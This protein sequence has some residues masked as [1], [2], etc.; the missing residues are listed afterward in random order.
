MRFVATPEEQASAFALLPKPLHGG[1]AARVHEEMDLVLEA[2]VVMGCE[3]GCVVGTGGAEILDPGL[4]GL[5]EIVEHIGVDQGL[6]AGMADAHPHAA[7]VVACLLY[8][9]DA[10]DEL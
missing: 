4:L 3:K 8:T 6:V 9:S 1:V 2:G 10:A 7:I 5:A